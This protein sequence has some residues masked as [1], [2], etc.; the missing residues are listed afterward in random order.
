MAY[1]SHHAAAQKKKPYR[2][3]CSGGPP[4]GNRRGMLAA[5]YGLDICVLKYPPVPVLAAMTSVR[6]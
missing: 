1:A 2:G 6:T 5:R 4:N 3:P